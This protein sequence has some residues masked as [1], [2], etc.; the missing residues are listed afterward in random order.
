T[1]SALSVSISTALPLST[2]SA[3]LL[4]SLLIAI[5]PLP[6][7]SHSLLIS[8]PSSKFHN[9]IRRDG[10]LLLMRHCSS[11][12]RPSAELSRYSTSPYC[13]V[14]SESFCPCFRSQIDTRLLVSRRG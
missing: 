8:A 1:S 6:L 3:T 10:S 14:R 13:C 12:Q 2:F 11:S 9:C 5:P 4:P 7:A